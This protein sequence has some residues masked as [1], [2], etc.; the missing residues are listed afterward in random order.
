MENI[1]FKDVKSIIQSMK[2]GI[3]EYRNSDKYKEMLDNM[4]KFYNYSYMNCLL[5]KSQKPDATYCGS[6]KFWNS[7][8]RYVSKGEKGIKILCPN[9]KAIQTELKDENGN[10]L[11]DKNGNP[12]TEEETILS[13]SVGNTFDI[14]QTYG[15]EL[16]VQLKEL[17]GEGLGVSNL[18]T[19]MQE[20][21]GVNQIKIKNVTNGAK[22][23]FDTI[24]NEIVLK[25]G[26]SDLQ[27]SKTLVHETAHALVFFDKELAKTMN[28]EEHKIISESVAYVVCK[29]FGLD[30][31]EYSFNYINFWANSDDEKI[32]KCIDC[33]SKTS[34]TIISQME[35]KLN[36]K[37]EITTQKE[38]YISTKKENSKTYRRVEKSMQQEIRQ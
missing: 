35:S 23:Y 1:D 26:M 28:I 36:L 18:I 2:K 7:L 33:I 27:M 29:R 5:I 4:A 17:S 38:S 25:D 19:V 30:T 9:F 13:F 32:E 21:S 31:S 11:L 12:K 22:G 16:N 15:K 34:K 14:S 8:G 3:Q 20:I 6:M 37:S 10:T 24:R